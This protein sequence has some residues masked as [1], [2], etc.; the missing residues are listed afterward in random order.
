[1]PQFHDLYHKSSTWNH[2][3]P[4]CPYCGVE[5]QIDDFPRAVESEIETECPRCEKPMLVWA[6][7]S[8]TF[9]AMKVKEDA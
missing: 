7:M 2:D 3:L 4:V 6:E 1:M 9:R 8:F 5:F